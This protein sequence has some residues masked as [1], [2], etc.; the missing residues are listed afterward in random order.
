MPILE[1]MSEIEGLLTAVRERGAAPVGTED[2]RPRRR[3]AVVACMDAR[4]DVFAV[5]GLER[6]DALVLRNAGGRVTEDVLRSLALGVHVLGVDSVL[7][8]QHTKCGVAGVTDEELQRLT[9]A[10]LG[11]F[12]I[13]DHVAALCEDV[14]TLA[15]TAYLSPLKLVAGLVYDLDTG[16]LGEVVRR[17]GGTGGA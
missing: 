5:L 9:G 10:N 13:D 12:P 16:E 15:T 11:F 2:R 4:I 1:A 14:E 3:L 6:G 17:G 8:V 7:V